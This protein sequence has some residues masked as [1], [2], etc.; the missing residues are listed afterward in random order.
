[1]G[2]LRLLFA[3]S[4]LVYH[5]REPQGLFLFNQ[6]AAIL[7]FFIISGFYMAL[8]LD[9]KYRSKI[10]FYTSR[11]LRIFPLYWVALSITIILG[12]IKIHLHLGSDETALTHYFQSS[13]YLTGNPAIAEFTN[14][15]LRN[16]TLL[17]TKDFFQIQ[18]NLH[19]GILLLIPHGHY[20]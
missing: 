18:D 1:M 19:R 16:F 10:S 15:I 6:T 5:T 20:K 3:L 7:S 17:L 14:F 2:V 9:G 4:V 12:F 13:T 11:V 8:I